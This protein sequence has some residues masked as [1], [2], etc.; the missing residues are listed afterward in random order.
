MKG[1]LQRFPNN[2]EVI[3]RKQADANINVVI[4]SEDVIIAVVK[5][6]KNKIF[7]ELIVE[8]D[9]IIVDVEYNNETQEIKFIFYD[10]TTKEF[11]I[12]TPPE[13]VEDISYNEETGELSI[14]FFEYD[15]VKF[16]LLNNLVQ[17]IT[18]GEITA[19]KALKDSA[20]NDIGETYETKQMLQPQ[21]EYYKSTSSYSRT[22]WSS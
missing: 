22:N 4:P 2:V 5:Q 11:I 6:M 14:T 9:K 1:K 20:G 8:I 17:K 3:L 7:E 15:Q 18:S 12:D 19:G 16:N 13:G 21:N 10:E